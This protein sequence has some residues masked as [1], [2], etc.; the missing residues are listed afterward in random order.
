VGS[1]ADEQ[2]LLRPGARP[3]RILTD[4]EGQRLG[5]QG[6]NPLQ[7][8]R[9]A[10]PASA[11][12]KTLA[13]GSAVGPDSVLLSARRRQLL[14][15]NTI[16]LG[17]RWARFEGRDRNTWPK[18]ARQVRA[19]LLSLAATGGRIDS[20]GI[21]CGEV[22]CDARLHS[23]NDLLGGTVHCLVSL[24]TGRPNEMRSFMLTHGR[25]G[26]LVRAVASHRLPPEPL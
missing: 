5:A 6:I 24:P 9:A 25:D 8:G 22:I 11:P 20:T 3:V 19:F 4:A 16:E 26:S 12:L 17:T 7:C 18:L 14:T 13:R 21:D 2:I 10:T 1:R 15:I 23:E